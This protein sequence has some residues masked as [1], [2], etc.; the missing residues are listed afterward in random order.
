MR[1]CQ[2]SAL[3]RVAYVGSEDLKTFNVEQYKGLS[4]GF[5]PNFI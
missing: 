1:M 3:T 4:Y 5:A 2:R